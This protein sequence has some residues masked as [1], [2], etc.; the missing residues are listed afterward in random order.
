MRPTIASTSLGTRTA[1]VKPSGSRTVPIRVEQFRE[2]GVFLKEG[3]VLIIAGV[4]PILG[5]KLDGQLQVFHSRFGFSRKAIKSRHSVDDVI[6][7]RGQLSRAEQML[8]GLV[9]ASHVHHGDTLL[10]MLFGRMRH[11]GI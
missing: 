8:P 3:E 10:V 7:L 9:P 6:G 11:D 1:C 4:I 5:T 2:S